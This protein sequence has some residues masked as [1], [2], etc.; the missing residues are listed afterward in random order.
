MITSQQEG[1]MRKNSKAKNV[2]DQIAKLSKQI[3]NLLKTGEIV[4]IEKA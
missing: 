4:Y 3:Q 2:N 1:L